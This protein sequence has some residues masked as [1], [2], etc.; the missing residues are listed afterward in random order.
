LTAEAGAARIPDTHDFTLHY[1][2]KFGLELEPFRSANLDDTYYVRGRAYR[3]TSETSV[4]WPLALTPDERRADLA[5]LTERYIDAVVHSLEQSGLNG[6]LP[7][8]L[9]PYD[10]MTFRDFLLGRGLS[11]DAVHLLTLGF[12]ADMGSAAWW[13]LDELNRTARRTFHIKGGNDMLPRAFA[14]RLQERVRYGSPIVAIGQM[15]SSQIPPA[16]R[17]A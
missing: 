1:I 3:L 14:A 12:H 7:V 13:L 6:Q 10:A 2:R 17:V 16:E 11:K 5:A 4:E 15:F 8:S 9:S